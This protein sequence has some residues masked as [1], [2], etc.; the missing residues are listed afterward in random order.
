MTGDTGTATQDFEKQDITHTDSAAFVKQHFERVAGQN[1]SIPLDVRK[2][3]E[4]A[5]L[6]AFDGVEPPSMNLKDE[7]TEK[8]LIAQVGHV[9]E[10]FD[11]VLNTL[12]VG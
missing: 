2:E 7:F 10:R 11:A 8:A 9:P 3:L 6:C 1:V 5:A 4:I 12:Q